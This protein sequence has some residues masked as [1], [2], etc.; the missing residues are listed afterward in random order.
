MRARCPTLA[1]DANLRTGGVG[2]RPVVEESRN[3]RV[4]ELVGRVPRLEQ[5][6]VRL[7][8]GHRPQDR[9]R[10]CPVPPRS[11]R[12]EKRPL[13]GGVELAGQGQELGPGGVC[14]PVIGEDKG[15]LLAGLTQGSQGPL[16]AGHGV[17]ADDAVVT[18]VA[19]VELTAYGAERGRI[20]V[21]D[22]QHGS[23]APTLRVHPTLPHTVGLLQS[24]GTP[25]IVPRTLGACW[26]PW[27]STWEPA[28]CATGIARWAT[29]WRSRLS[30]ETM[31]YYSPP[32]V[33]RITVAHD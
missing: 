8:L 33:T 32:L 11:P 17:L 13:G 30:V 9:R 20:V 10:R 4:E 18:A 3:G 7:P 29:K 6:G 2:S 19:H 31:R 22:E 5:V 24:P 25:R 14:Q 21:N 1:H 26:H 23:L 28:G 12:Y 16:S 15:H 27:A